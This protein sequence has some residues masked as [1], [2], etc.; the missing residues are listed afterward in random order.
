MSY[1]DRMDRGRSQSCGWS[2]F[3]SP[4]AHSSSEKKGKDVNVIGLSGRNPRRNTWE[5]HNRHHHDYRAA[6]REL[7]QRS[8]ADP[9]VASLL[10]RRKQQQSRQGRERRWSHTSWNDRQQHSWH[11]WSQEDWQDSSFQIRCFFPCQTTC[12]ILTLCQLLEIECTIEV[13]IS[14]YISIPWD[15]KLAVSDVRRGKTV[16][17][18]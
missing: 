16:T 10:N 4:H 2:S 11:T 7:Y 5:R 18:F 3:W 17:T 12:V 14:K 13:K 15:R 1:D 8:V 9:F 6:A